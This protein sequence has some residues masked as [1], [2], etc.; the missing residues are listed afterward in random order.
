MRCL[1]FRI[2][3]E[4]FGMEIGMLVEILNPGTLH[5]VP[6]LPDFI[7]GVMNVR[8][9]VI[10]VVSMGKRFGL[11]AAEGR[12]RVMIIRMGDEKVGLMVDH[13]YGIESIDERKITR[14]SRLFRGFRAEFIEG[15][16]E[17]DTER[18][19][20][21]MDMVKVLT[22]EERVMIDKAREKMIKSES[23]DE[24]PAGVKG[25][26]EGKQ[27]KAPSKKRSGRK[28]VMKSAGVKVKDEE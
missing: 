4:Y 7:P 20:I 10:P 18:V 14:P 25:E 2:G 26:K 27:G 9:E 8:G 5:R 22:R 16:A 3:M 28:K 13:V 21:L 11:E 23:G 6:E 17:M 1:V 24:K 12:N 15:I 19:L